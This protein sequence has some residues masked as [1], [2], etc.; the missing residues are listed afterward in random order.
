M[1][2][3]RPADGS[4]PAVAWYRRAGLAALTALALLGLFAGPAAAV[5]V[6]EVA[7]ALK[8]HQVYRES[9]AADISTERL[10]QHVAEAGT[11]IFIAILADSARRAY[12]GSTKQ[13]SS[14]I[15][16][17]VRLNGTY[18][19]ISGTKWFAGSVRT[20]P[21]GR[22]NQLAEQAFQANQGNPEAALVQWVDGV[23]AAFRATGASE[24][25]QNEPVGAGQAG[26]GDTGGGGGRRSGSVSWP[27]SR[28]SPRRTCWLWARTSG[29]STWTPACPTPTPRRSATTPRRSTSTSGRRRPSTGP[30]GPRTWP[31]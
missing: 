13:L 18:M 17:E 28:P 23:A 24:A 12:G 1:R 5:P 22:A 6:A 2:T 15:V 14:E 16:K 19:V 30:G 4:R 10:K 21:E 11:P 20:L 26:G 8:Q 9:D 25:A 3:S 31:R 29:P 27:R 7:T